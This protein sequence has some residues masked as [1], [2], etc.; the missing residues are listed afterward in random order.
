MKTEFPTRNE[1]P[2][3]GL[4]RGGLWS[5]E[6]H[7]AFTW[8]CACVALQLTT[9]TPEGVGEPHPLPSGIS[10]LSLKVLPGDPA[11]LFS[12]SRRECACRKLDGM[13]VSLQSRSL[14]A[15][16]SETGRGA[17]MHRGRKPP[18]RPPLGVCVA[19]EGP[20]GPW[21]RAVGEN[22]DDRSVAVFTWSA[23]LEELGD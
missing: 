19:V 8:G 21:V 13:S 2:H 11:C 10:S 15:F 7:V 23:V 6:L 3:G 1:D 17:R 9:R 20:W 12:V 5:Q 4:D 22:C 16:A 14:C 18:R